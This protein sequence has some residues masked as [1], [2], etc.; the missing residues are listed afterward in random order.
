MRAAVFHGPKD[1]RVEAVPEPP[2]LGP[3]EV[4]LEIDRAGIC[5]TDSSEYLH[6]PN[7]LPIERRHHASGHVGPLIIGHEMLGKVSAVGG[8]VEGLAVG[9]R[10]VPGAGMWC[11]E[12]DWC[13]AGKTNLCERY[14][15]LGLQA[16]GGMAE[17]VN[18]PER[19]CQTVP[20]ACSDRSAAVAQPLAVGLHAV[21]RARVAAGYSVAII[22]VGGIGFFILA[23]ALAEG[24]GPVVAIDVEPNR[25]DR[26][27]AY[28]ASARV[29]PREEDPTTALLQMTDGIGFDVVFEASGAETAPELA[30]AIVRRGGTILLVGLH[31]QPRAF[32][33]T[34]LVLREVELVATLA[35]VCDVDLPNALELLQDPRLAE[36]ALDREIELEAVVDEGLEPLAAGNVSGKIVIDVD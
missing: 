10:V 36:A 26:A 5:G 2:P 25:L 20:E 11:G 33:V 31:K 4:L 24:A 32:D 13:R 34:D 15:T 28:G 35:H 6:G 23:G 8:G 30:Q 9:D 7:Q 1:V 18:V 27:S 3:H 22:G 14:Y 21:S 17:L 16:N 29:N 19:M 12:C